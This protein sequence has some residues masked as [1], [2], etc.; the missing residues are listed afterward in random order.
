MASELPKKV[1]EQLFGSKS[2]TN[3]VIISKL[4]NNKKVDLKNLSTILEDP[5]LLD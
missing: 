1:L 5:E 4:L 2:H 3:D